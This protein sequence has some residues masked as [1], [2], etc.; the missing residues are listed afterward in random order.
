M[1]IARSVACRRT[2]RSTTDDQTLDRKQR[3]HQ[4][5]PGELESTATINA[6][7]VHPI[8]LLPQADGDPIKLF[9]IGVCNEIRPLLRANT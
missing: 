2:T 3:R 9:A 5:W 6:L 4:R 7:L 8:G 1:K